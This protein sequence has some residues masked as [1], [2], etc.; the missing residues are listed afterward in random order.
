VVQN[1]QRTL[2]P[3]AKDF[4]YRS[5]QLCSRL[6][7]NDKVLLKVASIERGGMKTSDEGFDSVDASV[8]NPNSSS[9]MP[10]PTFH[11]DGMVDG[12]FRAY[13]KVSLE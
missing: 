7:R 2:K 5:G 10:L 8:K 3:S 4:A 13:M 6:H 11:H 12:R 9:N 1:A